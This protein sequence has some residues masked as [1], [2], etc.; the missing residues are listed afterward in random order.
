V[1]QARE[2]TLFY[3]GGFMG[4][5]N[6]TTVVSKILSFKVGPVP[7]P[8]Y[9]AMVTI[10]L[11]ASF[12]KRLPIDMIGGFAT[13]MVLGFFLGDLGSRIPVLR[14]IGGPAILSIFIPSAAVAYHWM[15]PELIKAT[16]AIYKTSNFIY[17]Y[18]AALVTG[19]ILGMSRKI[20]IQGFLRMFV[21]LIVGTISSIVAGCGVGMLF[22]FEIK[23][24]FFYIVTPILGG[25]IGEGILPLT[26]AYSEILNKPQGD[27]I[28]MTLPAAMMGNVVAIFAAGI[29]KRL[30]EKK[31]HLSGNGLLVKSGEGADL[32]TELNANG[33]RPIDVKLMGAGLLLACILFIFG[34]FTTVYLFGIPG[35]IIMIMI[36]AII[37]VANILPVSMEHGAQFWYKFVSGT[38]TYPLLIGLG[39]VITPWNDIV[40]AITPAFFVICASVVIAMVLSGFYVGKMM[41]MF[42]VESAIVTTCHS[43]L[44]GTGDVAILSASDRMN[45][46]PFAQISTR[47]GGA[48]LVVLAVILMKMFH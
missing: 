12:A 38:W 15:N 20:L 45:L 6:K 8:I 11:A 9:L 13:I 22:G 44:G 5:S 30:G 1:Y 46:M 36:A 34:N 27:F 26:L 48:A 47:I 31:P 29:L 10:V 41:K 25:G 17:F 35:P 40:K 28:A 23:H 7:L 14:H 39:V 2:I 32:L 16:T 37:K 33:E 3:L 24:T 42:P 43:G 4:K 18:I 19:S 21:P